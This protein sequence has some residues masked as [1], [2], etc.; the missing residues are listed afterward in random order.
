MFNH[1]G[2]TEQDQALREGVS[3]GNEIGNLSSDSF[4]NVA[5]FLLELA[6]QELEG[7]GLLI[8]LHLRELD[9]PCGLIEQLDP[10]ISRGCE[11]NRRIP[12][13]PLPLLL[14]IHIQDNLLQT[15]SILPTSYTFQCLGI[16]QLPLALRINSVFRD[17]GGAFVDIEGSHVF[18]FRRDMAASLVSSDR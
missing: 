14:L 4:A 2:F 18:L 10:E 7:E 3:R 17:L 15:K 5:A 16:N 11:R 8:H 12:L 6:S 1:G 13:K 9:I